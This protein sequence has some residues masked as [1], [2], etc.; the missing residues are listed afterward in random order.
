MYEYL[1]PGPEAPQKSNQKTVTAA[2][3]HLPHV[4]DTI[5]LSVMLAF[6][7]SAHILEHVATRTGAS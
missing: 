7:P 1:F 5:V 2:P 4:P 6:V 3:Q